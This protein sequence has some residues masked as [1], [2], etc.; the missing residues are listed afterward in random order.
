MKH[1]AILGFGVVGSG[2]A[3]L[4]CENKEEIS[5]LIADRISIDCILDLRE[6]PDS[7]FADRVVHSFDAVLESKVD[8]VIEVTLK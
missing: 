6:F 4:L 7:P 1:I 5:R 2:V 8:T 3:R